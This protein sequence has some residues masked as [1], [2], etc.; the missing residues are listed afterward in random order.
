[1]ETNEM[2][3]AADGAPKKRRRG[4]R[5]GRRHR[6][7]GSTTGTATAPAAAAA[8]AA[9][10]APAEKNVTANADGMKRKRRGKRGGRRHRRDGSALPA[11][12]TAPAAAAP[13]VP[14]EKKPARRGGRTPRGSSAAAGEPRRQRTRGAEGRPARTRAAGAGPARTRG[15]R[16]PKAEVFIDAAAMQDVMIEA[17]VTSMSSDINIAPLEI[18]IPDMQVRKQSPAV[19]A[20]LER[21]DRGPRDLRPQGGDRLR[22]LSRTDELALYTLESDSPVTQLMASTPETRALCNR[23]EITGLPVTAA[24]RTALT[25][26]LARHAELGLA[27][28]A[29][30]EAG[31]L[32]IMRGGMTFGLRE[33][34]ADS[35]GLDRAT[36]SFVT[37]ERFRDGGQWRIR[38]D[39]YR[40]YALPARGVLYLADVVATGT[41]LGHVLDQLL[42]VLRS[43]GTQLRALVV[44]TIGSAAAEKVLARFH[45]RAQQELGPGYERT[46]LV[47]LE[48]RFGLAG[49]VKTPVIAEPGTDLLRFP[50]LLTPEFE[51]SQFERLSFPLERCVVYDLAQRCCDPQAHLAA[52]RKYWQRLMELGITCEEAFRERWLVKFTTDEDL[53][54]EAARLWA[55]IP[56]TLLA[57]CATRRK[58]L[59]RQLDVEGKT[60][61]ALIRACC[62]RIAELEQAMR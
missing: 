7:G 13:A 61:A 47:Y 45:K 35:C 26:V 56:E 34:L 6:R 25:R 2:G 11:A 51:L 49:E 4:K 29:A 10:A 23:P 62:Q 22:T 27:A 40:S 43:S 53:R 57:E 12:V 31:L 52:V 36:L 24:L 37:A 28:P 48:G 3:G 42:P 9:P 33:A 15:G 17:G 59:W 30:G 1:M 60:K 16:K 21:R 39:Q 14:A 55:D 5:G 20:A 44:F 8:P 58:E 50:A 32:T 19:R 38:Q 54:T 41:T 18:V 46:V